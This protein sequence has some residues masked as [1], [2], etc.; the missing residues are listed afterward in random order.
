MSL[1]NYIKYNFINLLIIKRAKKKLSADQLDYLIE[2]LDEVTRVLK[3]QTD[4]QATQRKCTKLNIFIC[5]IPLVF[6]IVHV[7]LIFT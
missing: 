6:S 3:S 4:N 2:N 5:S 1:L 7:C